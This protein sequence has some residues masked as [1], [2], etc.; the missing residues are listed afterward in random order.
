MFCGTGRGQCGVA[1][2]GALE[3]RKDFS[4]LSA[5]LSLR[6][7]LSHTVVGLFSL[8]EWKNEKVHFKI[9]KLRW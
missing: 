1:L 7:F 8:G 3:R 9:C 6:S 5:M 2:I 4:P